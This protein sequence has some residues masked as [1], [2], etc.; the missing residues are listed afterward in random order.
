[1]PLKKP[2]SPVKKIEKPKSEAKVAEATKEV[3]KEIEDFDSRI[4]RNPG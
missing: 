3:L 2:K 4:K 1:M